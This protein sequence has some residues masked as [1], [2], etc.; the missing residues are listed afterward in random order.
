MMVPCDSLTASIGGPVTL[1]TNWPIYHFCTYSEPVL[2]GP[3][4][5]SCETDAES[6]TGER[7]RTQEGLGG[8]D[9]VWGTKGVLTK[10]IQCKT[11]SRK[12]S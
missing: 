3:W 9:G 1:S 7:E 4:K 8:K 12:A 10:G 6:L 11:G 5:H 2:S